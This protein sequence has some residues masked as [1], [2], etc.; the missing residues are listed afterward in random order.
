MMHQR[1]RKTKLSDTRHGLVAGVIVLGV[2]VFLAVGGWL[3]YWHSHQ[4]HPSAISATGSAAAPHQPTKSHPWIFAYAHFD[5]VIGSPNLVAKLRRQHITMYE[6]LT[7]S[8]APSKLLPVIPTLDFHSEA[9]MEHAL[10]HPIPSYFKAV[11]YDNERYANTPANEQA[12][13]VTY[14]NKAIA[15]AHAHHL[16]IIC[17]YIEG[18]RVKGGY[19]PACDII[20]LN[21]V[22]Q[23]ERSATTYASKVA[24]IIRAVHRADP[25]V[26][27]IAGLSSNPARSP[28]TASEL[29]DD[30]H[31]TQSEVSGYWLNVPAPGVGCP[32]CNEPDPSVAIQMLQGM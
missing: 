21:T 2:A 10:A 32:D 19:T 27:I 22:Q 20:G 14:T 4:P 3:V 15:L 25:T 24:A 13:P 28:V 16:Q 26:P 23:S 1:H 9:A 8:Q 5:Q 31:S 12:D 30:I 18:D 11:I 17:D 6:V 29:I 7:I